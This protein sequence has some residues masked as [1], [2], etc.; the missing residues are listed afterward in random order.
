M[1]TLNRNNSAFSGRKPVIVAPGKVKAYLESNGWR[2]ET[3]ERDFY[4]FTHDSPE[5]RFRRLVLPVSE[6]LDFYAAELQL[7]LSKLSELYEKPKRL[8]LC[9]I[10]SLFK[11]MLLVRLQTERNTG[12]ELFIK[13]LPRLFKGIRNII[14]YAAPQL[15]PDPPRYIDNIS[16]SYSKAALR[17]ARLEHTRP[18]SFVFPISFDHSTALTPDLFADDGE[19]EEQPFV[20]RTLFKLYDSIKTTL[21]AKDAKDASELLSRSTLNSNFCRT[22]FDEIR[23]P[24]ARN[25]V[26]FGFEWSGNSA[27]PPVPETYTTPLEVAFEDFDWFKTVGQKL[28]ETE[29]AACLFLAK[30]KDLKPD[31]NQVGRARSGRVTVEIISAGENRPNLRSRS[32]DIDLDPAQ[33]AVA[34]K[35]HLAFPYLVQFKAEADIFRNNIR[36]LS[37]PS[38]LKIFSSASG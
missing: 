30:V 34:H 5:F 19:L 25:H 38:G 8:I 24:T 35:A 17:S 9:E 16:N 29:T 7:L 14:A 28:E 23:L 21:N 13:D 11:D 4:V 10:N 3:T 12:N 26:T 27:L 31:D 32:L 20:R 6:E 1:K 2:V 33:Y 36:R 22:F 37:N 18:G 15:G